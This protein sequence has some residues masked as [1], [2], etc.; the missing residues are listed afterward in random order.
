MTD[1]I[2]TP[3][4]RAVALQDYLGKNPAFRYTLSVAPEHSSES[5]EEFLF[6]T[7][8]GYCEQFASAFAAM[9]R[10]VGLPTRIAVGYTRGE[11]DANGVYHVRNAD[12]HAWPEVYFRGFGWVPLEPTPGRFEDVFDNGEPPAGPGGAVPPGAGTSAATTTTAPP[13]ATA[14]PPTTAPP[15]GGQLELDGGSVPGPGTSRLRAVLTTLAVVAGLAALAVTGALAW[16]VVR[17]RRRTRRRRAAPDP[18]DRVI[19]AWEEAMEHLAAAGI[20]RRPGATAL[21]FA[22][23]HAPAAG[24]GAAGPALMELAQLQTVAR[25]APGPPGADDAARAWARAEEIGAAVRRQVPRTTRWRRLL[26]PGDD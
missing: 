19:G 3:W 17:R 16:L 14:G 9:A 20:E 24:A 4:G 6:E 23:R 25:Y 10:H 5:I 12:A 18:R 15:A 7:R 1:G 13:P 21:E 22:L 2:E 8:A 11:R 26:A